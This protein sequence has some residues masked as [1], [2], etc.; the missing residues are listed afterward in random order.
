MAIVAPRNRLMTIR[1]S[2]SE[3]RNFQD[4]C[5]RAGARSL[6]ERARSAL[7]DLMSGRVP[8]PEESLGAE[9]HALMLR[10]DNLDRHVRDFLQAIQGGGKS[11][12][13]RSDGA[14]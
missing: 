5:V 3:Y 4:F 11:H 8:R 10:V 1:L 2:E 6:S 9:L 13:G 7:L 12:E 14:L